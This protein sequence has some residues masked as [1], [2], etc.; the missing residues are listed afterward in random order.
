MLSFGSSLAFLTVFFGLWGGSF[1]VFCA[2]PLYFWLFSSGEVKICDFLVSFLLFCCQYPL[3]L[4]RTDAFSWFFCEKKGKQ[5]KKQANSCSFFAFSLSPRGFLAYFLG[6]FCSF[7]LVL[8]R[9]GAIGRIFAPFSLFFGVSPF[10]LLFFFSDFL[11]FCAENKKR[12]NLR[13]TMMK[14]EIYGKLFLFSYFLFFARSIFTWI[15]AF[16]AKIA[17]KK[18][19][20]HHS[21]IMFF[22]FY[23]ENRLENLL[24]KRKNS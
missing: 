1:P 22:S 9:I 21:C 13:K 17:C 16:F 23:R 8:R 6:V 2:L 15:F 4:W 18:Y 19:E 3:F 7:S 10:F 14:N 20:R 24:Q 11:I 12:Q 5:A